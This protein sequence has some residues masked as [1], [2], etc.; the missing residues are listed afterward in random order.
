MAP[1]GYLVTCGVPA[2]LCLVLTALVVLL[3]PVDGLHLDDE[4][5][6]ETTQSTGQHL[7][8]TL[9]SIWSLLSRGELAQSF[10]VHTIQGSQVLGRRDG[11]MKRHTNMLYTA[12]GRRTHARTHA[13][14]HTHTHAHT[15]AC[16][17]THEWEKHVMLSDVN[18]QEWM[19]RIDTGC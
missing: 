19:N 10:H 1:V 5:T 6:T 13:R 11:N 7:L 9:V 8:F 16:A 4:H 2:L 3:V 15:H 17:H 14:T 18:N 12:I